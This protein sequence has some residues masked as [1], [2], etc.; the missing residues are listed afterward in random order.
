MAF[1][2]RSEKQ[3]VN[4]RKPSTVGPGSYI[5]HLHYEI[6]KNFAPFN[7]TTIRQERRTK[8]T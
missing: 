6:K 7:G 2:Y 5:A 4:L 3:S 1:V 8:R